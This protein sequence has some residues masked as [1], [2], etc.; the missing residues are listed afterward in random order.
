MSSPLTDCEDKNTK[1]NLQNRIIRVAILAD[2]PIGWGSGKHFFPIIL[3]DYSW[4]THKKT[5]TFKVKYL[6]DKDIVEGQLN[7]SEFDVLLVPG[8]GVGDGQA[9]MNGFVFSI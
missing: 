6:F 3:Q 7:T 5:Y 9:V 2:E 1:N 4:I 8:G